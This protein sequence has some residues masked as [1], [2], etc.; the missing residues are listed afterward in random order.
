MTLLEE[1]DREKLEESFALVVEELAEYFRILHASTRRRPSISTI[2]QD[3]KNT[4][5]ELED[6]LDII[7][8]GRIEEFQEFRKECKALW[9]K[10]ASLG[11]AARECLEEY[12]EILIE[13]N[14]ERDDLE[15]L[16]NGPITDWNPEVAGDSKF[17]KFLINQI[18]LKGESQLPGLLKL[19]EKEDYAEQILEIVK[20]DWRS[21]R[22]CHHHV[23]KHDD[24][25][26]EKRKL[27]KKAIKEPGYF[28]L[29]DQDLIDKII[30]IHATISQEF[31]LAK[32]RDIV[33][34]MLDK[35]TKTAQHFNYNRRRV[36]DRLSQLPWGPKD[37]IDPDDSVVQQLID[38]L[39]ARHIVTITGEGGKGK[40]ALANSYLD[41]NL[42]DQMSDLR[43][44]EQPRRILPFENSSLP[45][46]QRLATG[47]FQPARLGVRRSG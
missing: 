11:E 6:H 37:Y 25:Y 39:E 36:M 20:F 24:E 41:R 40:T 2:L 44:P 45:L 28:F 31:D 15:R 16:Q 3:A 46:N 21:F 47:R 10:G 34:K 23:G 32:S 38:D 4:W 33:Q 22:N 27:L 14:D 12:F 13:I 18:R 9:G 29:Q 43:N 1:S 19:D 35:K 26:D 17:E 42:K 30:G 8:Q 5:D 7:S